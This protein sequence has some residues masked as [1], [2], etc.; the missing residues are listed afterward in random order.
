MPTITHKETIS[1]YT[2]QL[3]KLISTINFDD[4]VQRITVMQYPNMKGV[5]VT[6]WTR[7]VTYSKSLPSGTIYSISLSS[8]SNRGITQY[9]SEIMEL[10]NE[11]IEE[12][13]ADHAYLGQALK[14]IK[15]G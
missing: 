5:E 10:V 2:G 15:G 9:D 8:Y 14:T 3:S 6:S 7:E 13:V 11:L 4:G 12:L 1:S